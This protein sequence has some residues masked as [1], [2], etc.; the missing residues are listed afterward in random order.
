MSSAILFNAIVD[1]VS[2]FFSE[3]LQTQTLIFDYPP[4]EL[5]SSLPTA[6]SSAAPQTHF[7]LLAKLIPYYTLEMGRM[8]R[9]VFPIVIP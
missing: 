8:I 3:S 2:L 1:D 6:F 4:M 5:N 9:I 7:E